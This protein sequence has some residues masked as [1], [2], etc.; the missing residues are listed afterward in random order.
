MNE[1]AAL[2]QPHA[3]A[4]IVALVD[5]L[6][7]P[8]GRNRLKA[9]K[10][11]LLWGLGPAGGKHSETDDA[12]AAEQQRMLALLLPHLR[13]AAEAPEP[14]ATSRPA[15]YVADATAPAEDTPRAETATNPMSPEP[16]APPE[17]NTPLAE[18]ILTP[19]PAAAPDPRSSAEPISPEPGPSPLAAPPGTDRPR[20]DAD[21]MSRALWPARHSAE[22]AFRRPLPTPPPVE[23]PWPFVSEAQ[24]WRERRARRR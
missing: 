12:V 5:A 10:L 24:W 18:S 7:S 16:T 22:D 8:D 4:I 9:A 23:P 20:G 15:R 11:L 6:A 19:C 1:T 2:V 13:S 14:V 21:P 17:Q 3:A